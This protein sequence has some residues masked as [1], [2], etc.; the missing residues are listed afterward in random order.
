[1]KEKLNKIYKKSREERISILRELSYISE[2]TYEYLKNTNVL[3]N[4]IAD[5]MIENQ[6]SIYGLPIGI[7]TNMLVDNKEYIVPMVIEEPSVIAAANNA[8]S[9][10]SKNGG[11]DTIIDEREMI[12]QII[13]DNLE[14]KEEIY[15]KI[16]QS[17]DI[18]CKIANESHPSIVNLGGGANKI[19]VKIK[20]DFLIIY[21]YAD[22]LDAMGANILN[23][24]LEAVAKY[25]E[26]TL[27]INNLMSILSNYA[28]SALVT[29]KCKIKIEEELGKRIERAS[30]LADTDI[31]RATTNNKGIFNGIDAIAI[32]TGNDWRAIEAGGHAYAT[33]EGKY[34]SLTKWRYIDGY[35]CGS[36]TM[37]MPI[38]TVGGSI[39]VNKINMISLEILNVKSAKELSK[40]AVSLGL[41]QNFA[42]LRALV[43]E[44]IQKGHMKLHSRSVA[45]SAGA[46]EDEIAYVIKYMEDRKNINIDIAKEGL[47]RI[48]HESC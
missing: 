40:I 29:S 36:I 11:F 33:R 30:I 21:L 17:S 42:A 31:Y 20:G 44:G 16:K 25:L 9:I 41:A 6:I 18:I 27:S 37:P 8:L 10:I 15:N 32:A 43:S 24:M 35:I 47:E 14:K 45:V 38:A 4:N 1:M 22:T 13:Y 23:T 28:T 2:E 48:R 3:T 12:G 46:K 19:E 26:E 34:A 7:A 39:N 5:K